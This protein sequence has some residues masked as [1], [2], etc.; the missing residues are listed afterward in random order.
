M[1]GEGEHPVLREFKQQLYDGKSIATELVRRGNVVITIDMFYWGQRRM[2]LDDDSA[3]LSG[4]PKDDE[5][6]DRGV[7][8][9]RG[10][11]RAARRAEPV[12][13]G[14]HLAGR[15]AV[16]RHP[17]RRLSCRGVRKWMP[18][19]LACVGLSVGGYRSFLLAALDPTDQE[20]PWMWAGCR[21]SAHMIT[22]PRHR[23][24][25]ASSFHIIGLYRYL[26]SAGPGR[27]DCAS[28][29]AGH[30]RLQRSALS[31]GGRERPHSRRSTSVSARR[32]CRTVNAAVCTTRR[33]SSMSRCRRR[34]GTG[35]NG[36]SES[37]Q[38]GTR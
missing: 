33:T 6:G 23:T 27:T 2:L 5:R 22:Q 26:D 15:P 17:D 20:W 3:V 25:S 37:P 18:G 30:Q 1:E 21:R 24:P 36:G 4:L 12:D 29:A 13:G 31:A 7:Q 14:R 9:P 32:A 35:S 34:R 16:G 38:A 8:P 10:A 28:L 11:E 19:G